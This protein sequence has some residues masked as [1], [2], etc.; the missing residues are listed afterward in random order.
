VSAFK[1]LG[2][3]GEGGM[4]ERWGAEDAFNGG[5]RLSGLF[6]GGGGRGN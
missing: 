5:D 3:K 2:E 4:I 1:G 6:I